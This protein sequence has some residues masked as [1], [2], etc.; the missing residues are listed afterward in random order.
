MLTE[1]RTKLFLNSS[2]ILAIVS[3]VIFITGTL[4]A[5][6]LVEDHDFIYDVFST[7]GHDNDYAW[8]F[9]SSLIVSGILMIPCFPAIYFV[10]KNEQDS[11]PRLLLAT[12]ILGTLIGPFMSMAGV[13]NEGDYFVLHLVFAI[14]AYGFVIFAAFCW[15]IYVKLMDKEHAYKRN[16]IWYLDFSVNVIILLFILAYVITVGFFPSFF[17]GHLGIM[18]KLTIYAFFVF[19]ITILARLLI[20]VNKKE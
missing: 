15:G 14:G 4:L 12:T 16:K 18:E 17:Y 10:M 3:I 19:F 1:K 6:L 2:L 8:L 13:F 7:T 11:K 20:I 9:N 5:M